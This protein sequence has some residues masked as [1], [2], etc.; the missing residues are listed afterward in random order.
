MKPTIEGEE[1][2]KTLST[3]DDADVCPVL[4][5]SNCGWSK[6]LVFKVPEDD[7]EQ[8]PLDLAVTYKLTLATAW[9]G[10]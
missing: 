4:A 8:G 3:E 2:V 6:H 1:P 7:A 5:Q 10:S 9:N